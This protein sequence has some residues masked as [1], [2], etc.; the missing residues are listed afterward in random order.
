MHGVGT[1]DCGELES[2][3]ESVH[4]DLKL[5]VLVCISSEAD[6]HTLLNKGV[7]GVDG[8]QQ[9]VTSLGQGQ[10]SL[11]L[12]FLF[13]SRFNLSFQLYSLAL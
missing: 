1:Y 3:N 6:S 2:R 5:G 10:L 8:S 13:N 12:I 9:I 7:L 11:R 4:S